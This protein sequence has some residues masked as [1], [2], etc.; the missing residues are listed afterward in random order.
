MK[1]V[2]PVY[3]DGRALP[4]GACEVVIAEDQ[5]EYQPLPSVRLM[6]PQ[7]EVVTRWELSDE[8]LEQVIKHRSVWLVMMTFN[9]PVTPVIITAAP[10][11]IE[12]QEISIPASPLIG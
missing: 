7:G 5:P 9:Q 12:V 1:P 11:E 4:P 2:S 6:N 10:P 3:P 8:E